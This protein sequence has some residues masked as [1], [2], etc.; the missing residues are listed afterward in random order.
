MFHN[1]RYAA[2][3]IADYLNLQVR[4]SVYIDDATHPRFAAGQRATFD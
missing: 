3:Y 1:M 2:K 4:P